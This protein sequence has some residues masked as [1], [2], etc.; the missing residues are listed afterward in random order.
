VPPRP[1]TMD[2]GWE[3]SDGSGS[4]GGSERGDDWPWAKGYTP[5]RL[6]NVITGG[7]SA[8]DGDAFPVTR[9][10]SGYSAG[11]CEQCLA[12]EEAASPHACGSLTCHL[13]GQL[14]PFCIPPCPMAV[15]GDA[16]QGMQ[17]QQRYSVG[18]FTVSC[19]SSSNSLLSTDHSCPLAPSPSPPPHRYHDRL[20]ASGGSMARAS[21]SGSDSSNV[22]DGKAV[23]SKRK[24][25]TGY[26]GLIRACHAFRHP[27]P[28][29]TRGSSRDSSPLTTAGSSTRST[30][31]MQV[32]VNVMGG[33]CTS[34][35]AGARHKTRHGV[36]SEAGGMSH[37]MA[38]LV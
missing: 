36:W 34:V 11:S 15:S 19:F 20:L 25:G 2:S 17:F 4:R 8:T 7:K 5:S 35:Q 32:S 16:L 21:S 22:G 30:A 1:S 29:P 14:T 10:H 33:C 6:G 28:T 38:S 31:R 24:A 26:S 37:V 18:R 27:T 23:A 13:C 9:Q 12:A 3:G